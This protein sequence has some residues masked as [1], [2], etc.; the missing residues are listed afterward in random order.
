MML[1]MALSAYFSLMAAA[2]LANKSGKDVPSAT[3]V[4]AVTVSS[5]PT[6]QPKMEAKS[7]MKAVRIPITA[8]DTKNVNQPPQI[9]TGGTIANNIYRGGGGKLEFLDPSLSIGIRI[10]AYLPT[11]RQEMQKIICICCVCE[12]A[13][14]DIHSVSNLVR[15][16]FRIIRFH[17][18]RN[19]TA[20]I[21]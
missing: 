17:R 8:K 21:S 18:M 2:R 5:S 9:L 12:V 6:K 14:I 10:V 1:P 15:P 3:K 20:S 7:P 13:P 16:R 11:E 4:M 19:T